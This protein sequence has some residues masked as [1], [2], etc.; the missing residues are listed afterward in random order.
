ML[1][2]AT[3]AILR[4]ERNQAHKII[5]SFMLAAN[6]AVATHLTERRRRPS[7]GFMNSRIRRNWPASACFSASSAMGSFPVRDT[8]ACA[9]SRLCLLMP[10]ESLRSG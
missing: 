2:G 3:E 9:I 5:E 1:S 6:E 7:T 8:E 4:A 10:R